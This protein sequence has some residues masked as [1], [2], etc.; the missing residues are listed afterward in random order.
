[1][2]EAQIYKPLRKLKD[3]ERL[4]GSEKFIINGYIGNNGKITEEEFEKIGRN[5]SWQIKDVLV[6]YRGLRK[7]YS[8]AAS[9]EARCRKEREWWK[10]LKKKLYWHM[11]V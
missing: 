2:C 3:N 5:F 9:I 10:C 8:N 11:K 4:F 6:I 7:L 1:M